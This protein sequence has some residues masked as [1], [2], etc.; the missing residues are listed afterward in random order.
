MSTALVVGVI[1]LAGVILTIVV[2]GW[3][4]HRS[5]VEDRRVEL[6]RTIRWA[7]ELAANTED[8]ASV[9]IGAGVLDAIDDF[10]S[11]RS[12]EDQALIGAILEAV[13]EDEADDFE[14]GTTY[15]VDELDELSG[16]IEQA[17]RDV[18]RIWELIDWFEDAKATKAAQERER[19]H[20]GEG[21]K[22]RTGDEHDGE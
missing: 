13:V 4:A 7:A 14:P 18:E 17:G 9:A 21:T 1:A 10:K 22:E 11:V 6:F 19:Y 8:E 15:Q 12:A 16:R 20:S 5:R 3:I 2:N